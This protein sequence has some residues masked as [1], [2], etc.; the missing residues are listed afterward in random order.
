MDQGIVQDHPFDLIQTLQS[1]PLP[2]PSRS[3]LIQHLI[4]SGFSAP[5]AQWMTT[6]LRSTSEQGFEWT[7][8]LKGIEELYRSYESSSLWPLL[9]A[10]PEG[11]SIHFVRAQ[12]SH[13]RWTDRIQQEIESLG[14]PG[15]HLFH[16]KSLFGVA[17]H[18]V[19]LLRDSGHWVHTD[20]PQGLFQILERTLSDEAYT[21]RPKSFA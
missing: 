1:I 21:A 10:P 20:N 12:H 4:S 3:D 19:H 13:F 15:S 8:D 16:L 17:G 14:P 6:N 5:V 18:Q 7:F 11:L 2:V 9:Q